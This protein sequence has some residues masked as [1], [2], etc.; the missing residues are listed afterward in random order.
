[1]QIIT[2]STHNTYLQPKGVQILL[3][4]CSI[5]IQKYFYQSINRTFKEEVFVDLF[6]SLFFQVLDITTYESRQRDYASKGKKHFYFMA[7]DG[8]EVGFMISVIMFCPRT[9]LLY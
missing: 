2:H 4:F 6:T 1:M 5:K 9:L 8:G 3:L 7:L